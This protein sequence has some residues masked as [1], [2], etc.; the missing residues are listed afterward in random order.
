MLNGRL[1]CE[2][3]RLL[4][5]RQSPEKFKSEERLQHSPDFRITDLIQHCGNAWKAVEG[6]RVSQVSISM[7]SKRTWLSQPESRADSVA[8]FGIHQFG[9]GHP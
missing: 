8:F 1:C 9:V 6:I 5:M 4:L 7:E 3:H 2:I